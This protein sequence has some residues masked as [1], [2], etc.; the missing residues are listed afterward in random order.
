MWP[1]P[2]GHVGRYRHVDACAEFKAAKPTQ[3][4]WKSP[5]DG[6]VKG[7]SHK[8]EVYDD[9]VP[10]LLDRVQIGAMTLTNV[11]SGPTTYPDTTFTV[12]RLK[13]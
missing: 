8:A 6:R 9:L 4:P 2:D 7:E 5:G 12:A 10:Q 13:A 1:P 11:I 3:T